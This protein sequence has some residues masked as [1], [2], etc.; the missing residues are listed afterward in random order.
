[1]EVP[2][3]VRPGAV[4]RSSAFFTD[5]AADFGDD[6]FEEADCPDADFLSRAGGATGSSAARVISSAQSEMDPDNVMPESGGCGCS[7]KPETFLGEDDLAMRGIW[8]LNTEME[9]G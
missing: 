9:R 4:E 8:R 1:M 2:R 3:A 5:F 7:A 6:A